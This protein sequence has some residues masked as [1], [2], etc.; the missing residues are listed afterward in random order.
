MNYVLSVLVLS[1]FDH[2]PRCLPFSNLWILL[3]CKVLGLI[4]YL[5]QK[6]TMTAAV[7]TVTPNTLL[8]GRMTSYLI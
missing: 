4:S 6:T 3:R 8:I 2:Y 7:R 5:S 1:P